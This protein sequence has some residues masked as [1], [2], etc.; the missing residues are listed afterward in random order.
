MY[1]SIFD[2]FTH[3]TIPGAKPEWTLLSVTGNPSAAGL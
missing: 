1:E 2:V 3:E